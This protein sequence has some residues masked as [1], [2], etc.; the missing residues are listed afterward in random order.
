M[1]VA[2]AATR[3]VTLAVD[4]EAAER[5]ALAEDYGRLRYVVR[6]AGERN[7]SSVL[8]A[9]LG[10]LASPIQ[11]AAGQIIATE[12]SPTNTKVGD[13]IDV[14]ITVRNTS[15]KP[16]QTMGPQPGFT[17]V[18]GQTYFTQQYASEPGKWRVA[19]GTA[20]LDATE[21]PYRWGLG[22]DLAPGATTTVSGQIKVTQD[23]K[24]TNFW[25]ALVEEPSKVVQTGA[26]HDPGDLV[27]R[28]PG[29]RG[30]GLG[31]RSQ[32]AID[33]R[34]RYRSGQVRYRAADHR[35]E[36]RLV[37]D[38]A[39]RPAR[40]VG[41]GW[42]DRHSVALDAERR[43]PKVAEALKILIVDQ[44][45]D[46]VGGLKRALNSFSDLEVV[47]DAGFGPVA[48]TWAYTLEPAL[49][50]V[51]VE[52]PVTR[53]LSTIQALTRGNPPWTVV[54]L[55]SQFDREVFRRAVLAGARD[56]AI[57]SSSP[58]DLHASLIQARRADAVRVDGLVARS[59]RRQPAASFRSSASRAGSARRRSPRIWPL[60]S[61]RRRRPA[62]RSSTWTCPSATSR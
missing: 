57:R 34:E 53:S 32:R 22:G 35:P 27:A 17:Y 29:H 45:P 49:I 2:P 40:R 23:F 25:A 19:I 50:I 60:P 58:L 48:S 37:Q 33:F 43:S 30:R 6:P 61:P 38:Q 39:A 47:G 16:M 12:I 1:P 41:G 31:Q 11:V 3:T 8:P 28:E 24:T 59:R 21:L 5:L 10:T 52:E 7:Q 9:D 44:H 15:D 56:V 55:V 18:Q 20:G 4:P 42:L 26:R 46:T 14:K 62:S 36:C 13:T 51:S 54:G